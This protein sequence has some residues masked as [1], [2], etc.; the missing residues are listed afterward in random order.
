MWLV[1]LIPVVDTSSKMQRFPIQKM[2]V[3]SA[4]RPSGGFPFS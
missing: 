4:C 2:K 3:V 1:V